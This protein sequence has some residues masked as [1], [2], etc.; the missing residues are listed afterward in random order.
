MAFEWKMPF[1]KCLPNENHAKDDDSFALS[2]FDGK[3]WHKI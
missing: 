3:E 1:D 2:R